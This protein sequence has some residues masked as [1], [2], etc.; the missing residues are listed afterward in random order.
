MKILEVLTPRRIIGNLGERAAIKFLRKNGY[1]ILKKNYA[2]NGAEVDVI[3]RK[4]NITAFIEVKTRSIK[5]LGYREPRPGSSVTPEKQ[6]K[7]IKAANFYLSHN[8][9]DTRLRFDVIEVY[10]EGDGKVGKIQE[11]KHIENAFD[12]NSA[13]DRKYHY[14][15][16]KEGSVL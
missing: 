4:D 3:A 15:R 13:Y 10:L 2:A 16:K 1:R 5:Y 6:R 8:P 14:L 9:A 12:L 11:I 7:I